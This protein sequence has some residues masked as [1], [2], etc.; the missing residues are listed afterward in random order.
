MSCRMLSAPALAL[1]V[2]ACSDSTGAGNGNVAIR[3]VTSAGARQA[4]SAGPSYNHAGTSDV[5][6]LTGT[7]GTLQLQDVRLIVSKLELERADGSCASAGGEDDE[8]ECEEF[9]GGPF[10]VDLPL[11]GG[12]VTVSTEQVAAGT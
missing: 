11:S 12:S 10:L 6:T 7:N 1:L 5:L 9:E 3:F 2:A 8:G 4:I